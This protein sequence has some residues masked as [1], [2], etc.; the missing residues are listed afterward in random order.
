MTVASVL[1]IARE[2]RQVDG[3]HFDALTE[4]VVTQWNDRVHRYQFGLEA[5]KAVFVGS[6]SVDGDEFARLVATWRLDKEFPG[7][8]GIGYLERDAAQPPPAPEPGADASTTPRAERVTLKFMEP[9]PASDVRID[10]EY[11][12][13]PVVDEA[14]EH[15]TRTGTVV[16]SD[17]IELLE[18]ASRE[19]GFLAILPVYRN[20]RDGTGRTGTVPVTVAERADA[21]V[22]WIYMPIVAATAFSEL[23]ETAERE[24]D[25]AMLDPDAATPAGASDDEA[26][27]ADLVSISTVSFGGRSW[28]VRMSST[29]QFVASSHVTVFCVSI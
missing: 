3:A 28:N 5:V 9:R 18:S 6:A 26:A 24:L 13:V 11:A 7:A 8:L 4:R 17:T 29:P 10:A 2:Q 19:T 1:W 20:G 23:D 27:E 25:V 16:A 15:A 21:V 12:T 22:G 14:I